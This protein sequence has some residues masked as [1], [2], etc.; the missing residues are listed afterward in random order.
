MRAEISDTDFLVRLG[1]DEFCVLHVSDDRETS[2]NSLADAMIGA[3]RKERLIEGHQIFIGASVGIAFADQDVR[4]AGELLKRADLA[5][6]RAK[7][8]GRGIWRRFRPE[9]DERVRQR[10]AIEIDLREALARGEFELYYQPI[11][12]L[13]TD[14]VCGFE[15]LLRWNRLS[16]GFVS[17]EVFIPLAEETGLIVAIGEWVLRRACADAATWPG[18]LSVA[19]NV[20]PVQ[21]QNKQFLAAVVGALAASGIGAGRLELEL[22]ESALLDNSS[23]TL[24]VLRRCRDLGIRLAMDDFGTGYSSLGYLRSFP[25]D[26]VKIDRSFVSGFADFKDARAVVRAVVG[27]G[28]SF[29]MTTTAEG[30]E[31]REQLDFVRG[32][33]CREVQGYLFGRPQPA[34]LIPDL[35]ARHDD[36]SCGEGLILRA[37]DAHAEPR[38]MVASRG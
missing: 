24:D 20:S 23:E 12:D 21:F 25:F 26:K 18:G 33:G 14:R 28:E 13:G 35:L 7:A 36:W 37:D 2:A 27:L 34:A 1:G 4:E 29:G 5:M 11:I 15:A 32:E 38:M 19:V 17:P 22:T 6:Y 8:D 30:V 9:M 3:I 10:R 16:L 31:T